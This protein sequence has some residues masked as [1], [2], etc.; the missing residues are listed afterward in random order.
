MDVMTQIPSVLRR[1]KK[2]CKCAMR[3]GQAFLGLARP[4]PELIK[5]RIEVCRGCEHAT[6]NPDPKYLANK[7]LTTRSVCTRC[8]CL[9][10]LK[11]RHEQEVCPDGKW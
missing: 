1:L 8:G 6:R 7:G 10:V 2:G 11:T 4:R 9:I 5:Q 3:A